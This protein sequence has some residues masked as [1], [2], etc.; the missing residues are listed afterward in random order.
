MTNEEF[1]NAFDTLLNSYNTK[2]I[3]GNGDAPLDIR[4]DEYEK[5]LFLSQAQKEI[6]INFYNGNNHY[7][8]SFES[9]EEIRRYLD[10]L[11]KTVNYERP[12]L[13][14]IVGLNKNS[15][16]YKLPNDLAF[17]TLE[18]VQLDNL[19]TNCN[20][21]EE[22]INVVP[23]TQDEYNKIIKNPFRKP[24]DKRVLR[25]DA[26]KNYV[27]LISKYKIV[28]YIIRYL[29]KPTPIILTDFPEGLSIDGYSNKTECELSPS[30]HDII[31]LRAVQLA[32]T[33]KNIKNTDS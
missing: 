31:L 33:T 8:K 9:T 25:L 10:T 11:I 19:N 21:R 5:S 15:T 23:T 28:N 1:S 7:G 30:I 6:I 26:G 22:R 29:I 4:L 18:Q 13:V 32:L 27:E 17:I 3:F 16:F 24:N 2:I 14:D 12:T 20:I